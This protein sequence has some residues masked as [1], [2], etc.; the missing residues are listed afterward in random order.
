VCD[1][2]APHAD[3]CEEV[4][5]TKV[6]QYTVDNEVVVTCIP[7]S[8]EPSWNSFF[9]TGSVEYEYVFGVGGGG[10]G[11]VP[12]FN[13]TVFSRENTVEKDDL[14]YTNSRG[15]YICRNTRRSIQY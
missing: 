10:G 1:R 4:P 14:Y 11:V 9:V 3:T 2:R 8:P 5:G 15:Q 12:V 13:E 6:I 7:P